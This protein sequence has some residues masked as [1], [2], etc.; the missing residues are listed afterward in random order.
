MLLVNKHL[1][2]FTHAGNQEM[3]IKPTLRNIKPIIIAKIFSDQT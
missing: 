3:Q 2:M 1:E